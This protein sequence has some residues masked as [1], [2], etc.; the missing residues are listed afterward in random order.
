MYLG[1]IV[2]RAPRDALFAA[3]R[4][5]YTR[6]L[7]SAIPV[8]DPVLERR[9]ERIVLAGDPPSP[10]DPPPGCRFHPRCGERARVPAD[11]CRREAPELGRAQE[12]AVACHLFAPGTVGAG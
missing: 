6:A 2:E 5:P 1:R 9:R 11:R 3:P 10:T 7:L 12:A 4:H 8:P